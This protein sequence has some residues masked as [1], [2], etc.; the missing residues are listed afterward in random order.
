MTNK[1]SG[2]DET[3]VR[4]SVRKRF[5][6]REGTIKLIFLWKDD[7]EQSRYRVH[8][9]NDE[10]FIASDA[11]LTVKKTKDGFD[12]EDCSKGYSDAKSD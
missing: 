10:R 7:D 3:L 4:Q 1:G 9:L 6:K 2:F 5:P 12:I 11:F 8:W